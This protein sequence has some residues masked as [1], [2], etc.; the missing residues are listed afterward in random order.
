MPALDLTFE[1]GG[2][3]SL[4]ATRICDALWH[5]FSCVRDWHR[6][7]H[8]DSS[9]IFVWAWPGECTDRP[10]DPLARSPLQVTR[11]TDAIS[12]LPA[13]SGLL[14]CMAL[15]LKRPIL[16]LCTDSEPKPEAVRDA[17]VFLTDTALQLGDFS[18][19][20]HCLYS[21]EPRLSEL[22][23]TKEIAKP[24]AGHILSLGGARGIVAE[25]LLRM[26]AVDSH[27]SIVGRTSSEQPDPDLI[28]LSTQ[29][30]MR[31]LLQRHRL[32]GNQEPINPRS[33]QVEVD[34]IRRQE[35]LGRH[36]HSLRHSV[37]TF[38]YHTID[39]SDSAGLTALL[40]QESMD[41]INVLISG[42]GVIQDQS[43][44][45]KS[46]DSFDAVLRTKVVPLC[47]LLT[48]GL[49]PSLNTWISFSSI[50]SKSGNPGQVDYAAANEF[51]NTVVHW[52]SRRQLDVRMH[53]INWGPWQG[54]GMASSEVLA[55]FHNRGLEPINPDAGSQ[56]L[57]QTLISE[58]SSV[59]VSAVALRPEVLH[60]LQLQQSLILSSPLWN[61]HSLPPS[62]SLASSESPLFF[63]SAIPY[64]QGHRKKNRFVVPAAS[65]L[66]L[67]AHIGD[68][69]SGN[70][71]QPLMIS[72]DVLHGITMAD[73]KS[74]V[75][76]ALSHIADDS[77]SGTLT[78]K[79][80]T[81]LRT[82]YRVK[83]SSAC[84]D[85]VN[86]EWTFSPY[87]NNLSLLY[88]DLS[89]V[90]TS[91]LF[92]SG[93]MAN[94]CDRIVID[95]ESRT[96]WCRAR[97][98]AFRD[99]LGV[100]IQLAGNPLPNRDLTL[101]DSL[102]QLLLV[103]TIETLGV[104]ALPTKL[105]F[106]LINPMPLTG[107]VELTAIITRVGGVRIEGV[108]ACR[109]QQGKLLFVMTESVFTASQDLLDHPPGI[110]YSEESPP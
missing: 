22:P 82:H 95:P 44:L 83:W 64:L 30:L 93:V 1:L 2:D 26:A 84:L 34:R 89:D 33:L 5:V 106:V 12:L 78:L 75:V 88:C 92:H 21:F 45:S 14:R 40:D 24:F 43:C 103:Q 71:N 47:V 41:D 23:A 60:R 10:T 11:A 96:S 31:A 79:E 53:T 67:A 94:L 99:L 42:A 70:S 85:D 52:F 61:F 77:R 28:G 98:T 7:L 62:D 63:H 15:E 3:P 49:P 69:L 101:L 13:L 37:K 29:D 72:L 48:R 97:P 105:S 50:A 108:G 55:A 17:I 86:T 104:S 65:V 58:S 54:S 87:S 91:C 66:C 68:S 59:E 19:T 32:N 76:H 74:V 100:D 35:A 8:R 107:E 4:L 73:D 90:Y 46:R 102:L 56:T 110:I 6:K 38:D 36:L 57:Y 20:E 25:M 18:L 51:L 80:S 39:L 27:L 81:G 9:P 16:L 109:D